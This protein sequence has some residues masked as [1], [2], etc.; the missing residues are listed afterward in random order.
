VPDDL[1][2]KIE[3]LLKEKPDIPWHRA[4]RLTVDPDA[5]EDDDDENDG[6]ELEDDE[7]LGDI[8]E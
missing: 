7:D 2:A 1:K 4:V 5:E 6:G 3:N 8:D